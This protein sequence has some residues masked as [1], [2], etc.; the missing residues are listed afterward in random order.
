MGAEE[1]QPDREVF[2]MH[3]LKLA[4]D[5]RC[6][7]QLPTKAATFVA[8]GRSRRS[9]PL[10]RARATTPARRCG[11]G[12]RSTSPQE[13]ASSSLRIS[14]ATSS[15]ISIG[16]KWVLSGKWISRPFVN[17]AAR[18]GQVGD[19]ENAIGPTMSP[20]GS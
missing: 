10:L 6:L 19:V 2:A 7:H 16:R 15:G 17:S 20:D 9:S 11:P 13:A 14:A 4:R 1:A 18:P 5:F 3:P 8:V 12:L